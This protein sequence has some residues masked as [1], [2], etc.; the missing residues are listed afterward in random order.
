MT[1]EV[2]NMPDLDVLKMSCEPTPAQQ[3]SNPR[4]RKQTTKKNNNNNK[5]SINNNKTMNTAQH[6]APTTPPT[7][8]IIYLTPYPTGLY[9]PPS[10]HHAKKMRYEDICDQIKYDEP[11]AVNIDQHSPVPGDPH[12]YP[13][14][15]Y[16]SNADDI[17]FVAATNPA[18]GD[19]IMVSP[20]DT[21]AGGASATGAATTNAIPSY[22]NQNSALDSPPYGSATSSEFYA[23]NQGSRLTPFCVSEGDENEYPD[24][25]EGSDSVQTTVTTAATNK[26]RGAK[27]KT[28]QSGPAKARAKKPRGKKAEKG[29]STDGGGGGGG[30]G[31]EHNETEGAS[32]EDMQSQRVMANVRERQRT[33]SL[34][35][36]FASLRKIIPTLPSDKLSKI[37]T[38]K[39]ASR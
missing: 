23:V 24:G 12:Y 11:A 25:S 20:S 34:N 29:S 30:T 17:K 22:Y 6:S 14:D 10:S 7:D 5:K 9:Q 2:L 13:G 15:H 31:S 32:Y 8:E 37:Q 39:L 16:P 21:A 1:P 38:L 35:E 26:K 27:P 33:Q 36:A 3:R 4:K 28:A 18:A 19:S